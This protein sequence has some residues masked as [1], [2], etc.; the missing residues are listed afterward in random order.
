MSG[1]FCLCKAMLLFFAVFAFFC[2]KQQ[3]ASVGDA[4]LETKPEHAEKTTI[5]A[6]TTGKLLKNR[7]H[8]IFRGR[9]G[10]NISDRNSVTT[11]SSW[12]RQQFNQTRFVKITHRGLPIWLDPVGVL[13]PQIVANLSQQLCVNVDLVGHG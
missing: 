9:Q 6:K 10:W 3:L 8:R 1:K 7:R 5:E 2:Y 11:G 4:L 13:D 12:Y